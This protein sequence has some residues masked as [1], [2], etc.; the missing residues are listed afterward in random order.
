MLIL[1]LE[2]R[3][4]KREREGDDEGKRQAKFLIVRPSRGAARVTRAC[5][6]APRTVL[7]VH[8]RLV[9]LGPVTALLHRELRHLSEGARQKKGEA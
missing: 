8:H 7:P 2:K 3:T 6:R 1:N 5:T 4:I 9:H